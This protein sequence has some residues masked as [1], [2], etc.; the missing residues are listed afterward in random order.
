MT[1]QIVLLLLILI[2]ALAL[3]SFEWVPADVAALGI[4]LTL[5]LTGLLPA[6]RA[7]AG[8]GSDTVMMM[9]GLLI[10]TATLLRTGVVEMA[11]RAIL[12][13]TGDDPNRLLV[14]IMLAAAALS[15]FISNTAATAFFVPL[16]VGLAHRARLSASKLLMPLAFAS[17]LA[18]SVTLVSTSTS[19]VVSGLMTG[20]GLRPIGMFELSPVGIPIAVTGLVYMLVVGHRLIPQR[21]QAETLTEEFGL[22]PYLSELLLRA[23]SP[24]I[25]K[26]LAESGLGRDL[27]LTV[28]RLIRGEDRNLAPR[29][30]MRLEAEDVLLVEGPREAILKVKDTAGIDIRADV[31]YS[32]PDLQTEDMCLVEAILLPRSP[33]IWRTLKGVRFREKY[34]LQVL[35]IDRHSETIRRKISEVQLRMGD[36][37]LVQGHRVNIAALQEDNTFRVLGMIDTKRPNIKRARTAIAIFAGALAAATFNLLSLPVA[38]LLGALLVFLTRC[39]TPEE[40]YREVEWKALILIGSMLG[41]GVA[42]EQTGAARFLAAQIV[43]LAGGAHPTWL[44]TAFFALTVLLTQPM[45]NQAAAVV[46]LPVALQTALQLGLNPRT[47]AVMIAVAASCSYLTPLEP[48]C[49]MVYG[50]GRYRFVDFLKV[51]APLTVLIYALAISLVPLVWPPIQ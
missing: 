44:L 22:R 19:I 27:D 18:S 13:R 49:L 47:F 38:V 16:V 46:V 24:L 31:E 20:Y 30:D 17:I 37:L 33:L 11:G 25:G 7:F 2:V 23:D 45:S 1:L 50:P 32:D 6:N 26:T 12:R 35:A 43:R 10:L 48:A 28:L 40:A 34:R 21:P 4:L 39:I 42:I 41:L 15:A 5:I 8:F 51:G 3:F 14:V 29:A 36:V 9:L